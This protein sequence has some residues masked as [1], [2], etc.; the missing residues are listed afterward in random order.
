ME[1]T[2]VNKTDRH[3]D[4][5]T[6]RQGGILL[7]LDVQCLCHMTKTT[8]KNKIATEK[9]KTPVSL[10]TLVHAWTCTTSQ[11]KRYFL[12]GADSTSTPFLL[13]NNLPDGGD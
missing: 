3:T 2:Q 7:Y 6:D 8:N 13:K 4:I 1:D 11:A 5:Q 10:S 9:K 12:T